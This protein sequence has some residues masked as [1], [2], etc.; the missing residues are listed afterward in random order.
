[1]LSHVAVE[2]AAAERAADEQL[3]TD[4]SR[5]LDLAFTYCWISLGKGQHMFGV[6]FS[7]KANVGCWRS[8][9]FVS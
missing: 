5:A 9:V 4:V 3:I 7:R 8:V 2:C 1:M 6:D